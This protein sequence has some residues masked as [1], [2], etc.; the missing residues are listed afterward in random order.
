MSQTTAKESHLHCQTLTL[1]AVQQLR[2]VH[3]LKNVHELQ[4]KLIIQLL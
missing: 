4:Q 1:R 2:L 3:A